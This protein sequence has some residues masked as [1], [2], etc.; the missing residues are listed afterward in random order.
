MKK[1]YTVI[2]LIVLIS[3][4]MVMFFYN[5]NREN[6]FNKTMSL[7]AY[8]TELV[9]WQDF[10]Y[11]LIGGKPVAVD[12]LYGST[13]FRADKQKI[14]FNSNRFLFKE[15]ETDGNVRLVYLI[16]K[17]K[18]IEVVGQNIDLFRATIG[19]E[20]T[21]QGLLQE[22][23]TSPKDLLA[24]INFDETLLGIILGF[25]REN[26]VLFDRLT[27]ITPI[28]K[29]LFRYPP[30]LQSPCAGSHESC[31]LTLKALTP[32]PG[33]N[34]IEEELAWFDNNFGGQMDEDD[35]TPL[36][37]IWPV[38]FKGKKSSETTRLIKRY[39]KCRKL[40]IKEFYAKDPVEVLFKQLNAE[41]PLSVD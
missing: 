7:R 20:I 24:V 2:S 8:F 41:N 25:G 6:N 3:F 35:F 31:S 37:L 9:Y 12:W 39:K 26:A 33:F 5:K 16:N 27:Q 10:G 38:G 19:S 22:I 14:I 29:R 11:A 32:R 15:S 21:P 17:K 13:P 1:K 28:N 23:E 40:L 30:R 18:F 36:D 34:S 4:L